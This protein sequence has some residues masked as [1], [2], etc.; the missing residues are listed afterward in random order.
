MRTLI[1][2]ATGQLGTALARVF[3]GAG[4]MTTT[5]HD[6]AAVGQLKL[7][8]SDR[9]ALLEMLEATPADV[10]AIAGAM[11]HVDGCEIDPERCARINV[12]GPRT[13]AEHARRVGAFV[14][15]YSTDHVFDGVRNEPYV[16]SDSVAPLNVYSRSKVEAEHAVRTLLP[17]CH[18]VLRTSW[19]YGPDPH[20]RNFALRLVDRLATGERVDVPADQWGSP[21]YTADL[22][23]ATRV[24]V[25]RRR[26]GT[27]HATGPDF[28][29]RA[30]LSRMICSCFG[31]DPSRIVPR[32]TVVLGQAARRPN[33][34]QLDT[35]QLR[36][37]EVAPFRSVVSGL[38]DLRA[39]TDDVAVTG[40]RR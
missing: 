23:Q 15:L 12:E 26:T 16:E 40:R 22:A 27:F 13:V 30:L 29:N 10:I 34:V 8:L 5:G 36:A 3:A 31:L 18:L 38:Q 17:D 33:R 19:V 2:G 9:A 28:V 11:C 1:I 6:H 32:P 39:E 24:L 7:D 25:E 37:A 21:T 20:R 4:P 14:V 35:S